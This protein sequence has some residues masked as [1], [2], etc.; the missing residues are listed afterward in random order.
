MPQPAPQWSRPPESDRPDGD[1]PL[2]GETLKGTY[3]VQR[4]LA[5]G[6]MGAVYGAHHLRLGRQFAIK[7]FL[8]I[9]RSDRD[10]LARFQNEAETLARL[11]H[12]N[13]VQV[14][15][16]DETPQKTP[17][18]VMEYLEGETL[19]T[20]LKY[21][22]ALPILDALRITS[23]LAAALAHVHDNGV[24]HCDLKPANVFLVRVEPDR[25]F[26]KMLDFG[27]SVNV[28]PR[29]SPSQR[30]V[31]TPG[32][33]TPEQIRGD[34]GLDGRVDQ[35][36]L[37][38]IAHEMLSGKP[39]FPG[40]QPTAVMERIQHSQ[41]PSL[42]Q[43][44]PWVP[45]ALDAV[46]RRALSKNAED[47]YSSIS[48]FAWALGNAA[49]EAGIDGETRSP[50]PLSGGR[51]RSIPP[52]TTRSPSLRLP[53]P[54]DGDSASTARPSLLPP[55]TLPSRPPK[56]ARAIHLLRAAQDCFDSLRLDE[57]VGY[58][59]ALF[60]LAVYEGDAE[61]LKTLASGL[62]LLERIFEARVGPPN[63][64]LVAN[65][66]S[67]SLRAELSPRAA[68]VLACAEEPR[69]TSAILEACG[70][71]RREGVRLIAGLLRRG[72][73]VDAGRSARTNAIGACDAQ[74]T[75]A[76]QT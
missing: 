68:Q 1:D 39:A 22:G 44:A 26:V 61:V 38:L 41:P 67:D 69:K 73:L 7:V 63:T 62:S 28:T 15:D 59:E 43:V 25:D 57:A 9:H 50:M 4:L 11:N 32:Y 27:V 37:A 21:H 53:Q 70:I 5:K 10:L 31:G 20:R 45:S 55:D 13:I 46:L 71:P 19:A 58:G 12:P 56:A 60:E 64:R 18:M 66:V 40:A 24:I 65:A 30:L 51:Y 48:R 14:L 49:I 54:T 2:I 16:I 6:G 72:A 42:A 52:R 75:A 33:M 8:D 23:D 36:A 29:R 35:F 74:L 17:Y 34:D 47:R 3:R 76:R